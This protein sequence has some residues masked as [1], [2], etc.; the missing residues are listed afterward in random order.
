MDPADNSQAPPDVQVLFDRLGRREYR[1]GVLENQNRKLRAELEALRKEQASSGS[2]AQA[3]IVPPSPT[4]AQRSSPSRRFTPAE[5]QPVPEGALEDLAQRHN[6]L[7][8]RYRALETE[9][10]H[11]EA[12]V[13]VA[14]EKYRAAKKCVA[15]WKKYIDD[16]DRENKPEQEKHAEPLTTAVRQHPSE[17]AK[18]V[19][20]PDEDPALTRDDSIDDT[21]RPLRRKGSIA[22]S[23]CANEEFEVVEQ[24]PAIVPDAARKLTG[25]AAPSTP[26]E[27]TLV[28]DDGLPLPMHG[29]QALYVAPSESAARAMW[30]VEKPDRA[31]D[32][33]S[34]QG[35]KSTQR[36]TS[37][38]S[39]VDDDEDSCNRV[40][41]ESSSGD[42]PTMVYE[43]PVKRGR[44]A[45]TG[46][47]PPPKRI[48]VERN[49]QDNS[50]E[51]NSSG[52]SSPVARRTH[53]CRRETSDLDALIRQPEPPR[54]RRSLDN[55]EARALSQG[56]AD[57][58]RIV[59]RC[60]ARTA[61]LSDGDIPCGDSV[62]Q[63][64]G[65]DG[66][67]NATIQDFTS[68]TGN[69]SGRVLQ[70]LSANVLSSP[71]KQASRKSAKE[72]RRGESP[73]N[74]AAFATDDAEQT[75]SQVAIVGTTAKAQNITP[76][77]GNRRLDSL[78][79]APSADRAAMARRV[80]SRLPP[81][82]YPKR[83]PPPQAQTEPKK[84]RHFDMPKLPQ[85]TG[86]K[87]VL[88]RARQNERQEDTPTR[89][90]QLP[91]GIMD[92]PHPAE[93]EEEPLRAKE[94]EKLRLEDFKINPE[95]LGSE[96]AFADT[97][98]GRDQ[99]RGLHAVKKP[100]F[101]QMAEMGSA[102]ALTGK[103]D[104]E[105]LQDFLGTGYAEIM[106]QYGP[107]RRREMLVDAR[108]RALANHH[109]KQKE[110]F[111]RRSTPPG[112]WRTD[113]PTTQD[114]TVDKQKAREQ[115]RD[116]IKERWRE[117]LVPGGRWIFRD[118]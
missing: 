99:R 13:K 107:E 1:I 106:G 111:A 53:H 57:S 7:Y 33:A 6:E 93:P 23:P 51:L 78:L 46:A 112:F 76:P 10:G 2:G 64:R 97:L 12:V 29:E 83:R 62:P 84:A 5:A 109:G 39:T 108:A 18:D 48:K 54:P 92:P 50:V 63:R 117:A 40:K 91:K 90:P 73:L 102:E 27:P 75:N 38:Q 104:T 61:S 4:S 116:K 47:M 103:S 65:I 35:H 32:E 37:S 88:K 24:H 22:P 105:V 66:H 15:Q 45:A 49:T 41:H 72:R 115:E 34:A 25:Q 118:E 101:R 26:A 86:A 28:S 3:L 110:T 81:S 11:C 55:G 113:F 14:L 95:Y 94:P 36:I 20:N 69:L 79:D 114:H 59:R 80:S 58:D 60:V 98:R 77:Q 30:Q 68:G 70:P 42:E 100:E 44:E 87:S 16:Q 71:R 21:P 89:P 19:A 17:T 56:Q 43:R 52:P 67:H 85:T 96:F 74:R 31:Q 9:H 82:R 8:R